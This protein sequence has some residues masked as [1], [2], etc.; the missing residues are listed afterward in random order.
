MKNPQLN[1][2]TISNVNVHNHVVVL[3]PCTHNRKK[4]I[5]QIIVDKFNGIDDWNEF[6]L[7][8][9]IYFCIITS[10]KGC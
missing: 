9:M 10:E 5:T 1:R 3:L 7:H 2:Q 8:L 6:F 4:K